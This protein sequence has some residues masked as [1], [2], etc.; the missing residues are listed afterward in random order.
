MNTVY[1]EMAEEIASHWDSVTPFLDWS[2]DHADISALLE[3][4]SPTEE[5]GGIR[6]SASPIE[7]WDFVET[8]C[9]PLYS[10]SYQREVKNF[11]VTVT[12]MYDYGQLTITIAA[13]LL[14]DAAEYAEIT[15]TED[16]VFS[17]ITRGLARGDFA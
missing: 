3:S 10:W 5:E 11:S 2:T 16:D 13:G 4:L 9:P 14:S 7:G 8:S 15:M 17:K 1:A 6:F 12:I